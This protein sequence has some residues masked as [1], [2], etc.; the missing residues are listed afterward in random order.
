MKNNDRIVLTNK[1]IPSSIEDEVRIALSHYPELIDTP[2]EFKFKKNI[3]KSFMQA[4]PKFSSL[5]RK[6]KN[7]SYFVYISERLHIEHEE[8]G[9]EDI[10]KDVLIGW[11]GHELGHIMDYR[12]RKGFNMLVFGVKYIFSK[13]YIREAERAADTYAVNHGMGEYILATKDFILN[14]AHLSEVYKGRIKRLY[15][16]PEEIVELVEELE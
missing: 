16:S 7:R 1:I 2:I 6:R 9:V 3:K 12:D 5:F 8:F 13:R 10:P 14:H 4:Q 11:I 15:L